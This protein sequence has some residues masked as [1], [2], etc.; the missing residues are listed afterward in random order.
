MKFHVNI[1]KFSKSES[2]PIFFSNENLQREVATR[3]HIEKTL[4]EANFKKNNV[5]GKI[6][7]SPIIINSLINLSS[8]F[9]YLYTH[10][11]S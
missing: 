4:S 5:T 11:Y 3:V 10:T 6:F 9:I 2:H 7:A 8:I 1:M